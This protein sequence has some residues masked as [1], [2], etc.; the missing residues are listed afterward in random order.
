MRVD[1][2]T[3]GNSMG[4]HWDQTGSKANMEGAGI[5]S[6][7]RVQLQLHCCPLQSSRPMRKQK[8]LVLGIAE[9]LRLVRYTDDLLRMDQRTCSQFY[10]RKLHRGRTSCR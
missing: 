10:N 6:R 7:V 1:A 2:Y 9:F 4:I 5:E 3:E 8:G